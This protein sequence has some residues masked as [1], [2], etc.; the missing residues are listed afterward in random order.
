MGN[1]QTETAEPDFAN[2]VLDRL[3]TPFVRSC[4]LNLIVQIALGTPIAAEAQRNSPAAQ[5]YGQKEIARA[6]VDYRDSVARKA[7]HPRTCAVG[8]TKP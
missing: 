8:I 3:K 5:I 7:S 4:L 6:R 2:S 1:E